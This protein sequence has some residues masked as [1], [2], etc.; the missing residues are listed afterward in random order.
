MKSIIKFWFQSCHKLF[1]DPDS[2][3]WVAASQMWR[4]GIEV[5]DA[6]KGRDCQNGRRRWQGRQGESDGWFFGRVCECEMILQACWHFFAGAF[7][8]WWAP[9]VLE[10]EC[11]CLTCA[12]W[13]MLVWQWLKFSL[14]TDPCTHQSFRTS[15][16]LVEGAPD[17]WTGRQ[18]QEAASSW[19]TDVLARP[20]RS[21]DL[22][23]LLAP[24]CTQQLSQ[25]SVRHVPRRHCW[26]WNSIFCRQDH[27]SRQ[28]EGNFH[29][30]KL[31]QSCHQCCIHP[32]QCPQ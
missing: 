10:W 14:R 23:F 13:S 18:G 29:W 7:K 1:M 9:T 5:Q 12:L 17:I 3:S 28:S 24:Q 20:E 8:C 30:T 31:P 27:S 16:E 15:K 32:Q 2:R 21:F 6:K 22:N 25:R 11:M 4:A 26:K 19:R